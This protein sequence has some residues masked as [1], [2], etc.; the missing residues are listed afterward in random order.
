MTFDDESKKMDGI[1]TESEDRNFTLRSDSM[2]IS[3]QDVNAQTRSPS[4]IALPSFNDEDSNASNT[5]DD[6]VAV[7]LSTFLGAVANLCSATLGAGVL[8]LPFALEQAGLVCG[9]VLLL[10]SAWATSASIRLLVVACDKFHIATYE[11]V[12]QH[13]LGKTA[14]QVVETCILLF[15]V[16]VAVAYLIAVGDILQ[17]AILVNDDSNHDESTIAGRR[18]WAI[19]VVWLLSMLPLSCLRRMKSL[20]CA[21]GV[22]LASIGL[23]VIAA[24]YHLIQHFYQGHD[25]DDNADGDPTDLLLLQEDKNDP[26]TASWFSEI[27]Q[28]LSPFVGPAENS[29]VSVLRAC[30]IVLFAFSC[31]V[32]VCQIYDEL[33]GGAARTAA[34]D[35]TDTGDNRTGLCQSKIETMS[36]VTWLAVGMC[37]FLYTSISIVTLMDFGSGL[38]PNILTCYHPKSHHDPLL[39]T[40]FLAMAIAVVMAFPLNIFPAR[41]SIIQIINASAKPSSTLQEDITQQE[42]Q[43]DSFTL[44][45][46]LLSQSDPEDPSS[47]QRMGVQRDLDGFNVEESGQQG[48]DEEAIPFQLCQH[49][50]VTVF[51]AGMALGLA[52]VVPNISIVFGL[53]GGTTGSLL[54]FIIPGFLGVRMDR[55][56]ATA[57]ILVVG[58]SVV[59]LLTTGVTLFSTIQDL[60]I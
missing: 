18:R 6:N 20:Q 40:A 17:Q 7:P 42:S 25:P 37:G 48:D 60:R 26:S 31:Q 59:G 32:N 49:V 47:G 21:S 5:S 54:G 56:N 22:G 53:L 29:F 57:W 19:F 16:G 45:Q 24:T 38:K 9:I 14:K 1:A 41:V 13:V 44:N 36:R 39:H 23:L 10:A 4:V 15:C 50:S 52:L 28:R 2:S 34:V 51:V 55:S 3:S 30:P 33:P 11:R 35:D 8:S 43:Q 46:P 12:V 58:G 27:I